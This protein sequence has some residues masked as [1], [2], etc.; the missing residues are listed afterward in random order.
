MKR[1][2]FIFGMMTVVLGVPAR[3]FA[4]AEP[5]PPE[6]A[7]GGPKG[8][9]HGFSMSAD[10]GFAFRQ[11]YN[12]PI[13]A[14]DFELAFGGAFRSVSV[15]GTFGILYGETSAG[16]SARRIGV[17]ANV[18]FPISGRVRL[19]IEPRSTL[20]TVQRVTQQSSMGGIGFGVYAA[21]TFDLVDLDP[22]WLYAGVRLGADT[23]L[24]AEPTAL[25]WGGTLSLGAR[26]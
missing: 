15:Y 23:Y 13:Y 16:L 9:R 24:G 7:Q 1:S 8:P 18:L 17:G 12:V 10:A 11:V 4:Q 2:L 26:Y 6:P 25:L 3:A 22:W 21:A 14:G 20:F 19:G 5:A